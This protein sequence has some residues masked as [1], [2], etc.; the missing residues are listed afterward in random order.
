M[1]AVNVEKPSAGSAGSTD[2]SALIL[3]RNYMVAVCAG[4]P[5]PRR[6]TSLHIRDFTQERSLTNAA[7]VEERS[8]LSQTSPSIR[9][10]IRERNH[11]NAVIVKKPSEASQSSF[12]TS[13]LTPERDH[14]PAVNVAKPLPTCQSSSNI[15]KLI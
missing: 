12:S 14:M 10:F 7:N 5:F 1:D 13:G 6:H 2:I 3:E 8:F 4:K 11:M 9:E 15:R